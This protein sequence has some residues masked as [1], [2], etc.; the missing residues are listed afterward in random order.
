MFGDE[1]KPDINVQ[2]IFE[3]LKEEHCTTVLCEG[4]G[5]VL[6]GKIE[7]KLKVMRLKDGEEPSEWEEY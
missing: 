5:L 6:I 2:E 1:L 4:C 3:S 7:D